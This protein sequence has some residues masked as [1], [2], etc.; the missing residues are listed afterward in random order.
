M[1]GNT[2]PAYAN[3]TIYVT[4]Q[5]TTEVKMAK[6]LAGPWSTFSTITHPKMPYT[7]EVSDATTRACVEQECQSAA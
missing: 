1:A 4:N 6:S 2:A 3:G 7:V 5:G